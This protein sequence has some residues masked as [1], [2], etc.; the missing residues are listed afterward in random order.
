M[1]ES[2]ANSQQLPVPSE[3]EGLAVSQKPDVESSS[4]S[5]LPS[6]DQDVSLP[7]VPHDRVTEE[8]LRKCDALLASFN[9]AEISEAERS[10]DELFD[11]SPGQQRRYKS[12]LRK[13]F[14]LPSRAPLALIAAHPQI[15]QALEF[16]LTRDD[17]SDRNSLRS[18]KR[19]SVVVPA[20][21]EQISVEEF[22]K[23]L[24]PREGVNATSCYRAIKARCLKKQVFVETREGLSPASLE[25]LPSEASVIRFLRKWRQEYVAVRRGRSRKH[26]WETMQEPYVTRDVTQYH[27]GEL[28]I[29]DHTELD[30][31]VLNER[32]ELDRRWITSFIDFRTGL[33]VGTHLDWQPSSHTISL[34]FRNG[35]L[36]SQIKAFTGEKFEPVTMSNV[37]ETVMIDNGKDYRSKYTRRVF[38][39]IDFDDAARLSVQR[40][41]RLHYTL[42]YHAQSKAQIERWHRT[43]QTMLKY[44]PGYKGNQ[45]RNK[46]D[47]LAEDL[48]AGR[49]LPVDQFDAL[50]MVAINTYNNRIHRNLAGQSPLQ[51]YL[52]NQT[53]QRTIDLRVLDF[54]MMKKQGRRIRRCQV[55]LFGRE[56][57]SDSLLAFNEQMADVYF[58]PRD[59]G[60]ISIYVG[61]KF[62]AVASNKEM[63]GQDERSW[64]KILRDRK[65]A[66]KGLQVQLKEHRR[67]LSDTDAKVMLLEGELLNMTPVGKELTMKNSTPVTFLTGVE[68]QAKENERKIEAEKEAVEIETKAKKRAKVM[69]ISSALVNDR[70]R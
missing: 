19:L 6:H 31:M 66:E 47:S 30:F 37:P 7:S 58:D 63:I 16:V 14:K 34:A 55:T 22:L 40:M 5:R 8:L 28:W 64:L 52:T 46:P 25:D 24:Y 12:E 9:A 54:L 45:Y 70:I 50:V 65:R 11:I 68:Q 43:I 17:R 56:Y 60:F 4:V 41:T 62:A 42:R 1:S 3:V 51:C 20:T 13:L 10:I 49:I 26:D 48:K 59:L 69:S 21:G 53:Q 57:Y 38:G 27:P 29:G 32:G 18:A 35:V 61:G 67:G 23:S 36:G 39:K 15:K 44:L 33:I 2:S